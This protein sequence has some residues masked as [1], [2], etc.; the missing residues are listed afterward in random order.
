VLTASAFLAWAQR[1]HLSP[2]AIQY[3]GPVNLDSQTGQNKVE[4]DGMR[5]HYSAT[6]KAQ[7]VQEALR[8]W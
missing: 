7:I 5:K 8:G 6:F 3:D 1:L 4:H 2:E